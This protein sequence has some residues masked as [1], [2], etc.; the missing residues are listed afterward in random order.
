MEKLPNYL[1]LPHHPPISLPPSAPYQISL[2]TLS[3][4][5]LTPLP[6]LHAPPQPL[7]PLAIYWDSTLLQS[8]LWLSLSTIPRGVAA[9]IC[10][11]SSHLHFS[12]EVIVHKFQTPHSHTHTSSLNRTIYI[13]CLW[14]KKRQP[15]SHSN[16]Q[17]LFA[18]SFPYSFYL[19]N[20]SFW[21]L[22]NLPFSKGS[23]PCFRTLLPKCNSLE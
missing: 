3:P 16:L 10:V 12:L 9:M 19:N 22:L 17:F 23:V 1:K 14:N 8:P 15:I 13:L 6:R 2:H 11:C 4:H 7:S 18:S 5:L 21:G 20:L